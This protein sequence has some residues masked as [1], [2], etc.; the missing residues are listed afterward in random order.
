MDASLLLRLVPSVALA[1]VVARFAAPA[2]HRPWSSAVDEVLR[3]LMVALV[4]GRVAWL[5]LG[6]PDVWRNIPSTIILVRAGVLT[7]AGVL[8]AAWWVGRRNDED[9][10][11]RRVV[12]VPSALAGAG[13]W[14]GLCQI[15]GVCGGVPVS[16]GLHLPGR[17]VASFPA[18]YVEALL[19]LALAGAATWAVR[20]GRVPIAWLAGAT[21]ALVRVLLGFARPALV[22]HPTSDQIWFVVVAI[23]C[24]LVARSMRTTQA[25]PRYVEV[26]T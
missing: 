7:G 10:R 8:V 11:W 17:A 21:Y 3:V 6:G 22:D 24:V 20:R 2:G 13:L 19:A 15:E 12:A 16:W 1:I 9:R 25:D 5:L 14:Q 18:S 4:A 26:V 23:A